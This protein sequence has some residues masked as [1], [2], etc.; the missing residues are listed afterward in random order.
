VPAASLREVLHDQQAYLK[1]GIE[2]WRRSVAAR[3]AVRRQIERAGRAE[4][5]P[6]APA[7][8]P[9]SEPRSA[10]SVWLPAGAAGPD[11]I[12]EPARAAKAEPGSGVAPEPEEGTESD[13]PAALVDR[14][15]SF[16]DERGPDGEP[17]TAVAEPERGAAR[18]L[19]P[20]ATAEPEG[21]G[22]GEGPGATEPGDTDAAGERS[23]SARWL[24]IAEDADP[25]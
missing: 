13:A 4:D 2:S 16:R 18:W 7:A 8:E 1:Q 19:P 21:E 25:L 5:V 12:A 20:G 22:E 3:R 14:W 17:G 10:A 24:V 15:L 11:D 6:G 9:A 23:R